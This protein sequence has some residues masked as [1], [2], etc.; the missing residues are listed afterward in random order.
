M[1]KQ[2]FQSNTP[3]EQDD[4]S[5]MPESSKPTPAS[6]AKLSRRR[7]LEATGA[8]ALG[9]TA[10]SVLNPFR[11]QAFQPGDPERTQRARAIVASSGQWKTV[12]SELQAQGF[13]FDLGASNFLVS[14]EVAP[15]G[16]AMKAARQPVRSRGSDIIVTVD[17]P[18]SKVTAFQY[19][20]GESPSDR[21]AAVSTTLVGNER[22]V[23]ELV[24]P[25]PSG[26]QVTRGQLE[27]KRNKAALSDEPLATTQNYWQECTPWTWQSCCYAQYCCCHAGLGQT[28]IRWLCTCNRWH[29]SCRWCDD[30][31]CDPWY[32]EWYDESIGC[33]GACSCC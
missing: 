32:N 12:T 7:F 1:G 16:L 6:D 19:I 23:R 11:A 29:R 31:G 21:L 17:L 28:E 9:V 18:N 10:A 3:E 27:G 26:D 14:P 2:E 5:R 15:V 30:W 13:G 33:C 20:V 8:A 25:S 22:E 4:P 24:R